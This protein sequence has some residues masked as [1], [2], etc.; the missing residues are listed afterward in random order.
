HRGEA[1]VVELDGDRDRRPE[2]LH[3]RVGLGGLGSVLPTQREREADDDPLRLLRPDHVE[4][5]LPARGLVDLR[6]RRH[7][8]REST[9]G[10]GHGDAGPGGPV[11]EREDL[12]E[13]SALAISSR[14]RASASGS[15]SGSLPPARAIVGRPPPPPP[16]IGAISRTTSPALTR[17]ATVWSKFATRC[18]VPFSREPSTTAA[19]AW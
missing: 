14:A 2:P 8:T 10:I 18:T 12:H 16:T 9:C 17:S 3:E 13:A 1:L 15:F 6:D 7:R 4:Q 5:L 19:G 11:V